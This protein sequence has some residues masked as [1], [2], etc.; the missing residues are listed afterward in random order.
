VPAPAPRARRAALQ[1]ARAPPQTARRPL[2]PFMSQLRVPARILGTSACRGHLLTGRA[3]RPPAHELLLPLVQLVESGGDLGAPPI[4]EVL[5]RRLTSIG[6]GLV[7]AGF[8]VCHA[9]ITPAAWPCRRPRPPRS[10]VRPRAARART[11]PA[12]PPA[13]CR[14]PITSPTG[15]PR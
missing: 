6:Q 5:W 13:A 7:R 14:R 9:V 15:W 12:A 2:P 10:G 8:A 4:Q 3:R 1:R 11:G